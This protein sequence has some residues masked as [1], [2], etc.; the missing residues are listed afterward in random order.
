MTATR[1]ISSLRPRDD[2]PDKRGRIG[3]MYL[4]VIHLSKFSQERS[5][6]T[7][8]NFTNQRAPP[9]G[10]DFYFTQMQGSYSI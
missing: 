4:I 3:V 5:P 10:L 7:V 1:V 6:H 8:N 9:I 2:M